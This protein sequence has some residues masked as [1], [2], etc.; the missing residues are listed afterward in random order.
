MVTQACNPSTWEAETGGL[1]R[2][3][4]CLSYLVRPCLFVCLFIYL[5]IYFGTG[6]GTQGLSTSRLH[7]W[8]YFIWKQNLTS[9]RE[10]R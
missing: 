1:R 3:E 7:P 5:F 4:A 8:T 10:L 2:F 6:D 9:C